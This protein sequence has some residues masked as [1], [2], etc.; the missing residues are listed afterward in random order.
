MIFFRSY[1][2]VVSLFSLIYPNLVN[3]TG[4]IYWQK[5]EK[6]FNAGLAP[7]SEESDLDFHTIYD[8][9]FTTILCW[10]ILVILYYVTVHIYDLSEDEDFTCYFKEK[11]FSGSLPF[12][13]F[14]EDWDILYEDESDKDLVDDYEEDENYNSH[15]EYDEP[16]GDEEDLNIDVPLNI[17]FFESVY[18]SGELVEYIY[19]ARSL[20]TLYAFSKT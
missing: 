17:P 9:F 19:W 6:I 1:L 20:G 8:A 3:T 4:M 18:N 2:T 15:P 14:T 7:I 10:L 11:E 13:V 12:V 16:E 5:F